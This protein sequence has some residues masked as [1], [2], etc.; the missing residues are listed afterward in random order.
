MQ[1]I[2]KKHLSQYEAAVILHCARKYPVVKVR[3]TCLYLLGLLLLG[4][5]YYYYYYRFTAI[6]MYLEW[7]ITLQSVLIFCDLYINKSQCYCNFC[8]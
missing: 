6:M 3:K 7:Y 5:C 2:E 1:N 8:G 4:F